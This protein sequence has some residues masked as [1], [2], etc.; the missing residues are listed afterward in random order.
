MLHVTFQKLCFVV[1]FIVAYLI[2]DSNLL[3][4]FLKYLILLQYVMWF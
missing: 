1:C 3:H 4:T 2:Y